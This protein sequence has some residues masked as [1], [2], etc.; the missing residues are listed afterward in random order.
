[1]DDIWDPTQLFH[2]FQGAA[3]IEDGSFAVV[4]IFSA[5]GVT[6]FEPL[7]EI[8]VVVDKIDLHTSRRNRCDLEDQQMVGFVDDEIHP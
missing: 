5:L 6:L 4:G 7:H 2:C 1:M 3:R 8:V